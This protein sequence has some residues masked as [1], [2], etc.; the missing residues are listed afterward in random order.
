M[1]QVGK[2]LNLF[3]FFGSK[4]GRDDGFLPVKTYRMFFSAASAPEKKHL[5]FKGTELQRDLRLM[6]GK[7]FLFAFHQIAFLGGHC[8]RC[9][10]T[11]G[12]AVQI[13]RKGNACLPR[14]MVSSGA[15]PIQKG[16]PQGTALHIVAAFP[17]VQ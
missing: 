11:A 6:D 7:R 2:S 16:E 14:W 5:D 17:V 13:E 4:N 15:I 10:R 12:S 3:A 1:L 8:Q 9:F